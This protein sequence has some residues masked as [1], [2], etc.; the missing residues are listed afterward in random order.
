MWINAGCLILDTP[1]L[2]MKVFSV[3]TGP[4]V[5]LRDRLR[6]TNASTASRTLSTFIRIPLTGMLP[7]RSRLPLLHNNLPRD[8]SQFRLL[9]RLSRSCFPLPMLLHKI[10]VYTLRNQV[11]F[12][13]THCSFLSNQTNAY[14][15]F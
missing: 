13:T 14:V 1:T 9:L 8:L 12:P 4:V 2:K 10:K 11:G 7:E 3:P 6:L 15:S 5:R